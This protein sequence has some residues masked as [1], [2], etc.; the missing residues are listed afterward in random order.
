MGAHERAGIH[1]RA[2][3]REV[4]G[5]RRISLAPGEPQ[6]DPA[7]HRPGEQPGQPVPVRPALAPVGNNRNN[8]HY[9][10]DNEEPKHM[11]G[12][13]PRSQAG[14]EPGAEDRDYDEERRTR[15][16]SGAGWDVAF[17]EVAREEAR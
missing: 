9:F 3:Q 16:E 1:E 10:P 2:P 12:G 17:N 8:A 14:A 5:D 4:S 7:A 11:P 6:A 15:Q 13:A